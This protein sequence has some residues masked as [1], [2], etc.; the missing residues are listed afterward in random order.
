MG[1][2]PSV[3]E[4]TLP[5]YPVSV[6]LT[7]SVRTSKSQS[8]DATC[9]VDEVQLGHVPEVRDSEVVT[10]DV[11]LVGEELV[12]HRKLGREKGYLS[13]GILVVGLLAMPERQQVLQRFQMRGVGIWRAHMGPNKSSLRMAPECE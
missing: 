3:R 7:Y 11:R 10:R 6:A 2:D 4:G 8:S 9:L 12:V 13:V 1:S 5:I